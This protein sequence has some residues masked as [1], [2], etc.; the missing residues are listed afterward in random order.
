VERCVDGLDRAEGL[1]GP[2]RGVAA[3]ELRL[4]RAVARLVVALVVVALAV[5]MRL[6][7]AAEGR[8][9]APPRVVATEVGARPTVGVGARR[10]TVGTT[11][12]VLLGAALALFTRGEAGEAAEDAA[13]RRCAVRE[14]VPLAASL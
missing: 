10:L 14:A 3:L 7:R 11:L 6:G 2:E 4:D 9:T 13:G 5:G 12:E 1:V 8:L